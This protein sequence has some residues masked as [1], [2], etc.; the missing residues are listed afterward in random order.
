MSELTKLTIAD[1]RDKMR[2]GEITAVELTEA[3]NAAAEARGQSSTTCWPRE[4]WA[5]RRKFS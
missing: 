2:A 3:C 4:E 1:A 5:T